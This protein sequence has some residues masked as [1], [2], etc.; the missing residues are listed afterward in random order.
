VSRIGALQLRDAVL[1]DGSFHSWDTAPLEV[2][3]SD[4]Y[5]RELADASAATGLDESV[6]T[7]EAR[8]SQNSRRRGPAK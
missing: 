2:A 3:T 7:G 6:L 4:A 5:R 8:C 1:D